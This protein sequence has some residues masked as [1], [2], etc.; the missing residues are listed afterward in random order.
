MSELPTGTVTFLFTD[1]EG[2]T[3]LWE[4]YP[5]AMKNALARHD[6]ILRDAIA[7]HGGHIVKMTGDGV[8]AA[9]SDAS[10]ALE[11]AR[12][13][14]LELG[15]E[16]WADTGPLR[17]R[18]GIHTGAADA[19]DGDYYGT[20][21]NRAA[22]LMSVAHGG[23]V[24]VSL[25]TEELLRDGM[26]AEL[27]LVDLGD[28]RLRDL[29][30]AERL[31]QLRAPGMDTQFPP[32]RTLDA[33]AG[34]LP[35]QLTSFV[36]RQ[37]D[38]DAVASAVRYARLVTLTGVGGV[39]KTRLAIQV[40][41][42]VLPEFPDGA[43]LCEL[44]AANDGETMID[45]IATA[46]GVQPRA[47]TTLD[48]SIAEFLRTKR[49]LILLDNCEH[50]LDAAA[51]F[52]DRVLR[53]CDDVRILATSREGLAVD[54]EHVR[55][56][57]SLPPTSAELLFAERALA[58]APN[59]AI[60][61]PHSG[62]VADVCRRLDGI[63][64]A[65][66]LAAARVSSMSPEEISSLLDERFRL[67][68]GGRRTAVER[69]QTLRAMVDWS[70]SLLDDT[71]RVVFD[72]LGVFSGSFDAAAA[73]DVVSGDGVE[74]WDVRDALASLVDRSMVVAEPTE[75]GV[76]RYA[77]LETLRAYARE[78]LDER[79][80]PDR[81][82][83]RHAVYYE[84]LAQEIAIALISP[85]EIAARR[86]LQTDLDNVRTAILW[87]L[88]RDDRADVEL[89]VGIVAALSVETWSAMA[90]GMGT[91]AE[92]ALA[93]VDETT[94]TRRFDVRT[95]AAWGRLVAR[96]DPESAA[97][98]AREAVEEGVPSGAQTASMGYTILAM[99][100]SIAGDDEG[101]RAAI[102]ANER[103]LD[104]IDARPFD[105]ASLQ[106]S[107]SSV[108][109]TL[110]DVAEARERAERALAIAQEIRHPTALA[111]SW[112][113]L[114][115]ATWEDD[116]VRALPAIEQSIALTREGA[117]DGALGVALVIAARLRASSGNVLVGLTSTREAIEYTRNVGDLSNLSYGLHEAV[118]VF[119]AHG[120]PRIA[121]EVSGAL[122]TGALMTM[123]YVQR[124]SETQSREAA[125]ERARQL[126][127][128]EEFTAA[129]TRGAAMTYDEIALAALAALDELI[130]AVSP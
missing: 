122:D 81:W 29:T 49:M 28:H 10:S 79:D 74:T 8:H 104:A 107:S 27:E 65:I 70:Y 121:A 48:G 92:L 22:R 102:Q 106:W 16:S 114:A 51:T 35:T 41:A 128:D 126:L 33:Y 84:R 44:A 26:P 54:G 99:A 36:G 64:L 53:A 7:A 61:A 57:R 50:L 108:L 32:L 19:R 58:V 42:E 113:A 119:V 39:G 34:N 118:M 31:F 13:L 90:S 94:L 96:A 87:A 1:L 56:L 69:H 62:A 66:E 59:F 30:R 24:L 45:V 111:L 3:R 127:G 78:R 23:Q 124:P 6:G 97:A 105:C 85:D 9:F 98:L 86:R 40:A 11:V 46:L 68:T 117:G 125:R 116:P 18:M 17:V 14:Q 120:A 88:D 72:R 60:D 4:Q 15:S 38:L 110:G 71:E 20:A 75:S 52:A 2:S 43:W 89:G 80:D 63:P 130:A 93:H 37:D 5:D 55:P 67:L 21:V 12:H 101:V 25:T 100:A 82:R 73:A 47:G 129:T 123:S 95:A 109:S 103:A 115:Y 83:R 77:M 112:F 76:T 91:W